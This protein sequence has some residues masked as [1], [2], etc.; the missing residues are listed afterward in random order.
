M[1]YNEPGMAPDRRSELIAV[2]MTAAETAML[3]QLAEADGLY[4][5]DVIRQLVRLAH[6]ERFGERK[7]PGRKRK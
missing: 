4:Q 7:P 1:L 6:A 3:K 5:S 2:R